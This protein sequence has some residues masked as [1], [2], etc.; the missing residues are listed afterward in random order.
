M[1]RATKTQASKLSTYSQVNPQK[2]STGVEIGP[3]ALPVYRKIASSGRQIGET[4]V[5]YTL[6]SY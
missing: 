1:K 5:N 2:L 6:V 4:V 3:A